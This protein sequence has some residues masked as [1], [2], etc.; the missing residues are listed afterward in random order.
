MQ[1]L[2]FIRFLKPFVLI[3]VAGA[4]VSLQGRYILSSPSNISLWI[5]LIWMMLLFMNLSFVLNFRPQH[6][7]GLE[8]IRDLSH[9]KLENAVVGSTEVSL[10]TAS[11]QA[12]SFLADTKTAG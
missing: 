1:G 5:V 9:G 12:G 6:L 2:K 10:S 7:S 8:L 3:V 11:I 4:T